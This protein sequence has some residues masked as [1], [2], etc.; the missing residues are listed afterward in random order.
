MISI[1]SFIRIRNPIQQQQNQQ[2]QQQQQQ[3][4]QQGGGM[5]MK[6]SGNPAPVNLSGV[7]AKLAVGARVMRGSRILPPLPDK[8]PDDQ[9]P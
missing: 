8:Q 6:Q 7:P 3:Q 2:H 5:P 9:Q 4:Q 1:F